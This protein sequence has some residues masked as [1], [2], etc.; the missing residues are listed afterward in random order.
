MHEGMHTWGDALRDDGVAALD[1]PRDED[2][3]GRRVQLLRDL[4]HFGELCELFVARH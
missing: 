4:L 3:C 2:L 1:A